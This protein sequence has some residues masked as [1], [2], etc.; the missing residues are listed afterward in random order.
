MAEDMSATMIYPGVK[1]GKK[2]LSISMP[3]CRYTLR[4]DFLV[5]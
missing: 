3:S 2:T 5:W 1:P 4:F